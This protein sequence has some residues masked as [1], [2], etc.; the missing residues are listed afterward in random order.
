[1]TACVSS[2]GW[3]RETGPAQ[4]RACASATWSSRPTLHSGMPSRCAL[5]LHRLNPPATRLHHLQ[6]LRLTQ[7]LFPVASSHD[8]LE[9]CAACM[10]TWVVA[11]R[12][13][14]Q[15]TT[16]FLY[17]TRRG[18]STTLCCT[19]VARRTPPPTSCRY[20]APKI[21]PCSRVTANIQRGRHCN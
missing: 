20:A 6:R 19:R 5:L 4:S 8:L 13:N 2:A 11:L 10:L 14:G 12:R 17:R 3:A 9:R 18:A 21:I 1:M 15:R 7:F 16:E